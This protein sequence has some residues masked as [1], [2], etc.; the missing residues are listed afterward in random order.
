MITEEMLREAAKE[1][2]SVL[3][4][5][6]DFCEAYT[7]QFSDEFDKKMKKV[8]RRANHPGFY[9][10][11]KMAVCFLLILLAGSGAVL[12]FNS[13]ARGAVIGWVKEQY[14]GFLQYYYPGE[15]EKN[16]TNYEPQWIP[17]GYQE[18]NR[19]ERDS[20]FVIVYSNSENQFIYLSCTEGSE[21]TDYFI[22]LEKMQ[23]KTVMVG[24]NPADLYIS[25]NGEMANEIVWSDNKEGLLFN[26][27]GFLSEEELIHIAECIQPEI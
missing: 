3:M 7:H 5:M 17:E 19:Y 23:K 15:G 18:V 26:I 4:E 14:E 21:S 24:K 13:S 16:H 11:Q 10:F 6:V 1:A 20:S 22:E 12:T 9:R 8:I 27:S 2:D 25:E